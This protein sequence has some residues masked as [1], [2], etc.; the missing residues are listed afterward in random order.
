MHVHGNQADLNLQSIYSAA[1]AEKLAN[2]KQAAEVRKRLMSVSSGEVEQ[3]ADAI[4]E[5]GERADEDSQPRQD[6]PEYPASKAKQNAASPGEA[7]DLP[8][9]DPISMWA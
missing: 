3:A 9:D 2:A 6:P 1:A 8:P 5:I 7:D 4:V